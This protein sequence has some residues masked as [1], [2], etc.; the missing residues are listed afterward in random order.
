MNRN[1]SIFRDTIRTWLD[2]PSYTID[3]GPYLTFDK[4]RGKIGEPYEAKKTP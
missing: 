2:E 1:E 3:Q 4:L